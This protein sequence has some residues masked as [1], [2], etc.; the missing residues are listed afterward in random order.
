MSRALPPSPSGG[1]G[2]AALS[3]YKYKYKKSTGP[4]LEGVLAKVARGQLDIAVRG[5]S[6]AAEVGPAHLS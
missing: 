6:M 4:L 3:K 1:H 5:C 2:G